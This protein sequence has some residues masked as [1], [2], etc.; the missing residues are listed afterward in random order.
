MADGS[1]LPSLADPRAFALELA[2]KAAQNI[3]DAVANVLRRRKSHA[4]LFGKLR[5]RFPEHPESELHGAIVSLAHEISEDDPDH[6][7][8]PWCLPRAACAGREP[9]S[10]VVW[11]RRADQLRDLLTAEVQFEPEAIL[12]RAAT[13]LGW[14]RNF[15]IST[16]AAAEDA[17][18][19]EWREG[20][21][22]LRVERP[23]LEPAELPAPESI[24]VQPSAP[25]PLPAPAPQWR[26]PTPDQHD[27][28]DPMTEVATQPTQPNGQALLTEDAKQRKQRLRREAHARR[29]AAKQAAPVPA[30]AAIA[31][32]IDARLESLLETKLEAKIRELLPAMV[33]RVLAKLVA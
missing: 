13:R 22:Q 23:E 4:Y 10:N 28:K 33:E 24:A 3:G 2:T 20:L 19:L 11:Q 32:S 26:N 15:T 21:W 29:K 17:G 25:E 31:S 18:L 27:A 16:L 7:Y 8:S 30:P 1:A 5:R 14:R 12:L 6:D 9:S